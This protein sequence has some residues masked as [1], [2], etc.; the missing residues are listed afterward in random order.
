MVLVIARQ[1]RNWNGSIIDYDMFFVVKL[2]NIIKYFSTAELK[3]T[4][5]GSHVV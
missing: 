1:V 5:K 2:S 3:I 4:L